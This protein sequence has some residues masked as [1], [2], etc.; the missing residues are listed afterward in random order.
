MSIIDDYWDNYGA[1]L[2]EI[3]SDGRTVEDVI[4]ICNEHWPVSSGDAFCPNG[5]DED[6][7][8]TLLYDTEEWDL[9]WAEADYYFCVQD[10]DGNR[11]SYIEG[12]IV[13][14]NCKSRV[15]EATA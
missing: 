5:G 9:V 4:R 14:G 8:G 7:L 15:K 11:L 10:R 2:A 12:D 1:C 13:R 3:K 6:L